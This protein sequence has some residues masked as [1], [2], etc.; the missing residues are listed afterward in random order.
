MGT[1]LDRLAEHAMERVAEKKKK[2]PLNTRSK[3]YRKRHLP[4]A[5]L[6]PAHWNFHLKKRCPGKGSILSVNVK[7]RLL[8]GG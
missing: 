5:G 3:K 4:S 8:P 1:I 2:H 7:R 6:Q